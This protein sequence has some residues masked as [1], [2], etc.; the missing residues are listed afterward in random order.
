MP[1]LQQVL[2]SCDNDHLTLV[3]VARYSLDTW[4]L[5][6]FNLD[7]PIF[8]YVI[9]GEKFGKETKNATHRYICNAHW[10][11]MHWR[12]RTHHGT[13]TG[14]QTAKSS[15]WPGKAHRNALEAVVT[16]H[17]KSCY[18]RTS[19]RESTLD[20]ASGDDRWQK[21]AVTCALSSAQL[22]HLKTSSCSGASWASGAI[23]FGAQWRHKTSTEGLKKGLQQQKEAAASHYIIG[24][25]QIAKIQ[26]KTTIFVVIWG[27]VFI[28][29]IGL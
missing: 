12:P 2:R 27:T 22:Q 26:V 18:S 10:M 20:A 3:V 11:W 13:N 16:S 7:V 21:H 23:Q 15:T 17:N 24:S 25:R 9:L 28:G 19:L 14:S 6:E 4:F 8:K 29:G 5:T 1:L